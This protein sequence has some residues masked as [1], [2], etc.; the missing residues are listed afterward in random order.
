LGIFLMI[1]PSLSLTGGPSSLPRYNCFGEFAQAVLS[2][3]ASSPSM[4][5]ALFTKP[6]SI[7]L[8]RKS[9]SPLRSLLRAER[10]SPLRV[11]HQ[12]VCEEMTFHRV[13]HAPLKVA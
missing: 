12:E 2:K 8:P 6:S 11:A 1:V 10:S 13:D 9:P 7:S 3:S 4:E 5:L